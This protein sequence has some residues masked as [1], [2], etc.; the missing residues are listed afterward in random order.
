MNEIELHQIVMIPL[1]KIKFDPSNPNKM[2]EAEMNGL[3]ESMRRFGYLD[4]VILDK[5]YLVCDGEH[6]AIVYK[7]FGLSEIP[8]M[9]LDISDPERRLLRQVKNK[10][11]GTHVPAKDA[12]ELKILYDSN[13]LADLSK[14]IA[15]DP[16]K[17]LKQIADLDDRIK[18]LGNQQVPKVYEIVVECLDQKEQERI[19]NELKEGG[20]KV[21]IL[22]L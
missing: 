15:G 12:A 5:N 16:V 9:V 4:P 18:E 13:R 3:R 8:A 10:L 7:E 1:D 21:R 2:T 19:Y 20:L 22:T 14:L 11:R 17:I 6:R